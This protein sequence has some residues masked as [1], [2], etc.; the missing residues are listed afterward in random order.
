MRTQTWDPRPRDLSPV[1]FSNVAGQEPGS[2]IYLRAPQ[3]WFWSSCFSG[4]LGL[5]HTA[6]VSTLIW[7]WMTCQ[8]DSCQNTEETIRAPKPQQSKRQKVSIHPNGT[9]TSWNSIWS[10]LKVHDSPQWHVIQGQKF[11]LDA[12]CATS[13]NVGRHLRAVAGSLSLEKQKSCFVTNRAF[14]KRKRN[15]CYSWRAILCAKTPTLFV[16][17]RIVVFRREW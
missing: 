14:R 17:E 3:I 7:P 5:A 8:K 6:H 15:F 12:L 4:W 1:H 9:F 16:G 2:A 10:A 13:L 11:R